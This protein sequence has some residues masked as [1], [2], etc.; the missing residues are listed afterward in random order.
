MY[1]YRK[2]RTGGPGARKRGKTIPSSKRPSR[3]GL[4]HFSGLLARV[5]ATFALIP[6][7]DRQHRPKT[8]QDRPLR[9][10]EHPRTAHRGPRVSSGPPTEGSG[11][12][13]DRPQR[14]QGSR[15]TA[16]RGSRSNLGLPTKAPG[17]ARDCPK[18]PQEQPRAAYKWSRA[19]PRLPTEG[20]TTSH[21]SI[22]R[23]FRR[24]N[25]LTKRLTVNIAID[26]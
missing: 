23:Q 25:T 18:R 2:K 7:Q 13:Q 26:Y 15:R 14:A 3:S 22:S 21:L 12:A 4:G 16:Y 24:K 20:L 1:I 10:Q 9:A 5:W 6:F 8:D 19:G 11:A 17:I